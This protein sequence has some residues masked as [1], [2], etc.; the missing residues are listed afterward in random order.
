MEAMLETGSFPSTF[1]FDSKGNM[2]AA[3][4]AGA[5]VN[6]YPKVLEKCLADMEQ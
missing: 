5:L 2:I 6:R 1:F 3:P 4:I